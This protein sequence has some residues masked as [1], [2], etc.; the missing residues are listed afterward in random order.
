MFE[1]QGTSTNLKL[2]ND[3]W[4]EI[5]EYIIKSDK[6]GF[7]SEYEKLYADTY[8]GLLISHR[9]VNYIIYLLSNAD[10]NSFK[11]PYA[12]KYFSNFCEVSKGFTI[13]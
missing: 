3:E 10:I 8:M 2:E 5:W 7:I 12:F 6:E 11:Y 4:K 1:L 9:K 13:N